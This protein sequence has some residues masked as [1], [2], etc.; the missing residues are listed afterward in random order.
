MR[1]NCSLEPLPLPEDDFYRPP[2]S[3]DFFD[4]FLS[5]LNTLPA[6]EKPHAQSPSNGP[7]ADG[8]RLLEFQRKGY[9]LTYL[10]ECPLTA[11]H[12]ANSDRAGNLL[13]ARD[14]EDD[15]ASRECISRLSPT[16]L[17]R[18]RFNYKPKHVALLGTNLSPLIEAFERAGMGPLLLLDHGAPLTIPGCGLYLEPSIKS[19]GATSSL[20]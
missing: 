1:R 2:E 20:P 8:A 12:F 11:L 7:E 5:S 6:P 10:S 18:I 15:P 9:Y 17:R 13:G 19:P 3:R 4:S 16:L 14:E